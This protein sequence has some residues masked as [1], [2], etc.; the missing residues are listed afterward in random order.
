MSFFLIPYYLYLGERINRTDQFGK[1][2]LTKECEKMC[3]KR[4]ERVIYYGA[5]VNVIDIEK[6]TLLHY[7]V[8]NP[9]LIKF[10][11]EKGVSRVAFALQASAMQELARRRSLREKF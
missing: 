3:L 2:L 8:K 5:D 7:S 1:S 4:I 9:I 11:L 10:F 6:N